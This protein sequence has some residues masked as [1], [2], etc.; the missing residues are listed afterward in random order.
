MFGGLLGANSW[1][2]RK[3]GL[4]V[5][6]SK[7]PAVSRQVQPFSDANEEENLRPQFLFTSSVL[8]YFFCSDFSHLSASSWIRKCQRKSKKRGGEEAGLGGEFRGKEVSALIKNNVFTSSDMKS[9]SCELEMLKLAE[10]AELEFLKV[11]CRPSGF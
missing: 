7:L 1:L 4:K 10:P 3:A 5:G 11:G 6:G 9:T 8:P 2:Q